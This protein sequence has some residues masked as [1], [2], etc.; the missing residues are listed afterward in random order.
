MAGVIPTMDGIAGI[1]VGVTLVMVD[2]GMDI[3]MDGGIIITIMVAVFIVMIQ[4]G[5]LEEIEVQVTQVVQV[6]G[7]ID[8]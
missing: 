2:I 4:S 1:M 7:L 8:Q 3:G 5:G 6:E